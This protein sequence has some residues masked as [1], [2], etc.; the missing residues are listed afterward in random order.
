MHTGVIHSRDIAQGVQ[1]FY[2]ADIVA[3]APLNTLGLDIHSAL[4]SDIRIT[5]C[6]GTV[7]DTYCMGFLA[8]EE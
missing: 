5:S 7:G 4:I 2:R 3:D 1:M 8:N 6:A